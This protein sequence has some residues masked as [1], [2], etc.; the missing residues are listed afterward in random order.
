MNFLK[1]DFYHRRKYFKFPVF[2]AM[3]MMAGH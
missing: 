1:N 3:K 2:Y